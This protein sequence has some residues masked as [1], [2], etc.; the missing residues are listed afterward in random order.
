MVY[1]DMVTPT[2]NTPYAQ[3]VEILSK[4]LKCGY[5]NCNYEYGIAPHIEPGVNN[6]EAM[7]AFEQL[8][9]THMEIVGHKRRK[10]TYAIDTEYQQRTHQISTHIYR[11]REPMITPNNAQ[12]APQATV[13]P[14]SLKQVL[15]FIVDTPEQLDTMP[16]V[17]LKHFYNSA[18]NYYMGDL[19]VKVGDPA[20][21]MNVL[22][23]AKV[24]LIPASVD[25]DRLGYI[26]AAESWVSDGAMK[27]MISFEDLRSNLVMENG[28]TLVITTRIQPGSGENKDVVSTT[29]NAP[30]ASKRAKV[31]TPG[32]ARGPRS[33]YR[34]SID[35]DDT[36]YTSR[37]LVDAYAEQA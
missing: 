23:N 17:N 19:L 32:T 25:R 24:V 22:S 35:G 12:E 15:G 13:K 34:Y 11:R 28:E 2:P 27:M 7:Q 10:L 21:L 6:S 1:I 33:K 4:P 29:F 37:E 3:V 9:Y 8:I 18:V 30:S 31:G 20:L 16:A 14:M 26:R 36:L 5:I